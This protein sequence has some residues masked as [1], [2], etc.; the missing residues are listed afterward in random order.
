MKDLTLKNGQ[1]AVFINV[2]SW[3]RPVY[4]LHSGT[5]VCCV[6]LNGTYLHTI[7]GDGEPDCPLIEDYQPVS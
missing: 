2:D 5:K 6:N 1:T 4:R 3:G 7:C